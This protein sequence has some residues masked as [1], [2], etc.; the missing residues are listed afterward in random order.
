M[1]LVNDFREVIGAGDRRCGG[2]PIGRGAESGAVFNL[3][4]K[5]GRGTEAN[6]NMAFLV[7][8]FYRKEVGSGLKPH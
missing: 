5:A 2:L 7:V 4:G 6:V 8:R 3:P 1:A